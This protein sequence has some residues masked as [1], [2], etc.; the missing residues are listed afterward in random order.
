MKVALP[1]I[2]ARKAREHQPIASERWLIEAVKRFELR[3]LL[4]IDTVVR[5]Q[6]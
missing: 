4:R 3:D 1:E 5:A 2:E 6:S